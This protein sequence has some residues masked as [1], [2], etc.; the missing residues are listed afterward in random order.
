MPIEA[1]REGSAANIPVLVGSNLDEWTILSMPDQELP[2]LDEARLVRVCK[3][4][5]PAEHVY[6]LIAAYRN[7]RIKRDANTNPPAVFTAIQ[8]DLMFRMPAIHL[9]EA[10][11]R[12]NQP[13]Y[14]YLFTWKSPAMG[15]ILGACHALEIGFVFGAYNDRFNGSGPAADTL[16][17]N[18]QDAWLAFARTGNPSCESIGTWPPYG[19]RR[20]TILLGED[21]HI[22]EAPYDEERRACEVLPNEFMGRV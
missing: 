16:A 1:I 15:G 6:G 7:A 18:M 19:E 21:C 4:L 17:R 5:M 12:H 2:K 20:V 9:A 13:A 22:E 14:N 10:Q 8:T 3:H 11:H